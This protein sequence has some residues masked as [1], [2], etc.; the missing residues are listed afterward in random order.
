MRRQGMELEIG[1]LVTIILCLVIVGLGIAFLTKIY[2]S[3]SAIPETVEKQKEAQL[4][5]LLIGTK[6]RITTLDST[7]PVAR[8][9]SAT[10]P[11]AF[12]NEEEAAS[13]TV[14]T[15][16]IGKP[17]GATTLPTAKTL[18]GPYQVARYGSQ[19]FYVVVE[20]PKEAVPG[21]YTFAVDVQRGEKLY[22]RTKVNAVVE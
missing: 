3:T 22:A 4:F 20:M 2:H 8:G 19:A 7:Q 16:I 13:F 5:N 12:R 21:E 1:T 17:A 11:I 10:Y 18:S 14:T 6:T 9:K 15:S